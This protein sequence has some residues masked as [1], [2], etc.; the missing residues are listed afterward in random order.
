MCMYMYY[1]ITALRLYAPVSKYDGGTWMFFFFC[2]VHGTSSPM[3]L[4][5]LYVKEKGAYELIAGSAQDA[6]ARKR[7]RAAAPYSPWW[8]F[9]ITYIQMG[10][11]LCMNLQAAFQIY[12]GDKYYPRRMTWYYLFYIQRYAIVACHVVLFAIASCIVF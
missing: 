2:Y 5:E 6:P 11:F 1:L 10:Q 3:L 7:V 9:I 4:S 8:K 12:A